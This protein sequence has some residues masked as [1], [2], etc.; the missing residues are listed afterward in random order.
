MQPHQM[1]IIYGAA[2]KTGALLRH[3]RQQHLGNSVEPNAQPLLS[4]HLCRESN[5]NVQAALCRFQQS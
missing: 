1:K 4:R 3:S 2:K 5:V